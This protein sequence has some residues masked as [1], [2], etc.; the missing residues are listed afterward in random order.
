MR[1]DEYHQVRFHHS[2]FIIYHL[3]ISAATPGRTF[4]SSNSRLAPPPVEMWLIL[5]ARPA[6]S[7]AATDSPPPTT[8]VAPLSANNFATALVPLAK[9]GNS[10]TPIGPFHTINFAPLIAAA[11]WSTVAG[12]MSRMRQP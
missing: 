11:N 3:S 8:V 6:C 10:N 5:S 7:T 9:F 4:P 12:P 2:S 1:N